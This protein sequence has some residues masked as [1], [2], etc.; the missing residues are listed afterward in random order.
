MNEKLILSQLVRSAHWNIFCAFFGGDAC[1][2]EADL[3]QGV[4]E[5]VFK[6][7]SSN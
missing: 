6:M 3:S 1:A 4:E 5:H 7:D 2:F